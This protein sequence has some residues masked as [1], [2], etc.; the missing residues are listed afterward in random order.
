MF[1]IERLL[2][3]KLLKGCRCFYISIQPSGVT[4]VEL[5]PESD[6]HNPD[7]DETLIIEDWVHDL[8]GNKDI[9]DHEFVGYAE[10]EPGS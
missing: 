9:T 4:D 10:G 5:E 8:R 7:I 6:Y 2:R 3:Y 1:N